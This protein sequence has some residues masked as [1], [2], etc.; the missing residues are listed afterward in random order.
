LRTRAEQKLA[1]D[2][3]DRA[4]STTPRTR[5]R[6]P[7][8]SAGTRQ[9]LYLAVYRALREG[10]IGGSW[11][12]G[13]SLPSEAQLSARFGVSRI[14]VRHALSLLESE[15]FIRKARARR[16]VVLDTAPAPRPRWTLESIE[17]I[18]AM[19]GNA[20]LK[21]ESWRRERAAAEAKRFDLPA[22]ARVHCL[23]GV[24]VRDGLPYARS[25]IYFPP[26][27]GSQLSQSAFDDVIV[28]RVLQRELGVEL[29]DV[30]LTVWAELAGA[31][32]AAVLPCDPGSALLVMQL[33]Y[34]E[35]EGRL[36]EVAY[37]RSLA[38]E[39]RLSTRL[40]TGPRRP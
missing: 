21:I 28:F 20:E 35:R 29:D 38:S 3:Q 26:A 18:I 19:V 7:P 31:E 17:D 15:G 6:R 11:E 2:L 24:L 27:V 8:D 34:R 36:V 25:V 39:V 13:G 5:A 30:R 33:L 9:P 22:A 16:P 12:A 4:V 40:T 1:S 10:L 32:D 23:R 14:T 37:S